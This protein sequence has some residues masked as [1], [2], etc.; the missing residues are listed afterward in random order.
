M[1]LSV[2]RMKKF[3]LHI[4]Y[5]HLVRFAVLQHLLLTL[6]D[7]M[8]SFSF[9]LNW[10]ITKEVVLLSIWGYYTSPLIS[11]EMLL[12]TGFTAEDDEKIHMYSRSEYNWIPFR[13][14]CS[15]ITWHHYI[16]SSTQSLHLAIYLTSEIY[17]QKP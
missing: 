7:R 10:L 6:Q 17:P 12:D 8:S 11:L 13:I 14:L 3:S 16:K 9:V 1:T 5:L 4:C 15:S 2:E